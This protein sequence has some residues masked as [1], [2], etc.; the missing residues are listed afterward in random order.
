MIHFTSDTHFFHKNIIKYS[1]RPYVSVNDMNEAMIANWNKQVR[2]TDTVFHLG[3]F[4]FAT[5][6]QM[7]SILGRLNGEKHLILGNHDTLI[8]S[9]RRSFVGQGLF[10]S[11]QEYYELRHT[12]YPLICLFHYGQR[13]WNGS[14]RGSIMLYGHSHGSLPPHGKSVDVG[15][16][17]KEISSEYRPYSLTEV[18]DYMSKIAFESVDHHGD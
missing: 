10:S 7:K 5:Y 6:S 1:N 13:V 9:N 15:V 11:I 12:G 3:D 2:P 4:A 14:H 17:C 18:L 16:D 8:D